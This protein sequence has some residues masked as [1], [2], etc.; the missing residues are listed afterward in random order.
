MPRYQTPKV[1]WSSTRIGV[2]AL[3]GY[4]VDWGCENRMMLFERKVTAAASSMQQEAIK[5]MILPVGHG[6]HHTNILSKSQFGYLLRVH[7]DVSSKQPA[8][9]RSAHSLQKARGSSN[10]WVEHVDG[11]LNLRIGV[12]FCQW[13]EYLVSN[14][15][16]LNRDVE[17]LEW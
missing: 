17:W 12:V 4:D 7:T 3:I 1:W 15:N 13:E 14:V 2:L 6:W 11:I 9:N 5:Y 8:T 16:S 10:S